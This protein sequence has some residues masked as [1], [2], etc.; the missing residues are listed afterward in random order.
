M[1]QFDKLTAAAQELDGFTTRVRERLV[2]IHHHLFFVEKYQD[3]DHAQHARWRIWQSCLDC[4]KLL[5][6]LSRLGFDLERG[7]FQNSTQKETSSELSADTQTE[8]KDLQ[9]TGAFTWQTCRRLPQRKVDTFL[10]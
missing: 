7:N 3:S 10:L 6:A 1:T 4:Q 9:E 8:E 2:E 5:S